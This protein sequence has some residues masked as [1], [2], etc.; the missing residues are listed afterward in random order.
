MAGC[1]R[2]IYSGGVMVAVVVWMGGGR[3]EE[4][5]GVNPHHDNVSYRSPM[6]TSNNSAAVGPRYSSS[7]ECCDL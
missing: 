4:G 5:R 3:W 6:H 2:R 1:G 7:V